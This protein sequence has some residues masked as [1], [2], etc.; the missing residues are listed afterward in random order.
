MHLVVRHRVVARQRRSLV[1]TVYSQ[2]PH[3][4]NITTCVRLY[5]TIH[6][7]QCRRGNIIST[8]PLTEWQNLL[9]TLSRAVS[10]SFVPHSTCIN[11]LTY[12]FVVQSRIDTPIIVSTSPASV[13]LECAAA[14]SVAR[15][16]QGTMSRLNNVLKTIAL[17]QRKHN[18]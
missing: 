3:L 10:G 11:R 4:P 16:T 8:R 5:L 17:T 13:L 18:L 6:R 9:I 14:R 1:K 7:R 15:V 2:T 12:R